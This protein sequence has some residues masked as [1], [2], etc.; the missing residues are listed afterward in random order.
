LT[1]VLFASTF[2]NP[3]AMMAEDSVAEAA[4]AEVSI[5]TVAEAVAAV[6][7]SVVETEVVAVVDE[8]VSVVVVVPL[9]SRAKELH[10]KT[11]LNPTTPSNS[12]VGKEGAE[13]CGFCGVVLGA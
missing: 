13:G 7:V 12:L 6:A 10:S 3:A 9:L 1:V 4:D 2:L 8:E 5:V 11:L